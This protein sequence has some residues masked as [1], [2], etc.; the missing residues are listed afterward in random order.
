MT[1]D[2]QTTSAA[3]AIATDTTDRTDNGLTEPFNTFKP[4]HPFRS[5]PAKDAQDWLD[6]ALRGERYVARH[7]REDGEGI[8]WIS[9]GNDE[10]NVNLYN[11]DA[12][13]AY[14]YLELARITGDGRFDDI[15]R[16]A[17]HRLALHWHDAVDHIA[18][19]FI[20]NLE[21]GI[22]LGAAGVGGVLVIAYQRYH[23]PVVLDA[24]KEIL[25]FYDRNKRSD[26]NGI[27]W[28]DSSTLIV[29]GGATLFLLRLAQVLGDDPRLDELIRGS[30]RKILSTGERT[31][32]GGLILNGTKKFRDYSTPN[33]ELGTSGAA[34][35][36]TQ[37]YRYT[38]DEDYLQAAQDAVRYLDEVSIPQ[39]RG[40]LI[41]VRI[42]P[43]GTP[44]K[45]NGDLLADAGDD[46]PEKGEL[47]GDY[48]E[49]IYYLGACHGP[50]GTGR[51][52]YELYQLTGRQE[53][54][55]RIKGNIDGFES[56]GAPELQSAGLW[57]VYYCCGHASLAQFFVG[58]YQRLGDE[59]W[60]DLAI[61]TGNVLL[62]SAEKVDDDTVD[63]P[64]AF[65]RLWPSREARGLG[66]YDGAAGIIVALLQLYASETGGFQADRLVDDPLPSE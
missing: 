27:Y 10:H 45:G 13:I 63:W 24:L 30:G 42:G 17:S 36:L 29:D 38:G 31:D 19:P 21:Y 65:L 28:G 52:W 1:T 14:L 23:D 11:G 53:Y 59:R 60:H 58:L 26:G 46:D 18:Y 50:A 41:P 32:K 34:Y 12:G 6:T 16:K 55:D 44:F 48:T 54:L 2:V 39:Q 25:D 3:D 9:D 57:S 15:A 66:Y 56:L 5:R 43:D 8:H 37:L 62:G 61:R 33:F 40:F 47:A 64:V 22:H 49:P 4:G 7:Q 20:D 51:L 35:A